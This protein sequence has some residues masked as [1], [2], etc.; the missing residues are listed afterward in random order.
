[1]DM[2]IVA[3]TSLEIQPAIAFLHSEQY[4]IGAKELSVLVAGVGGIATTYGLTS[5]LSKKKPGYIIQ[6]GIAG[7][8]RSELVPGSVACV[9]EEIMGDLGAEE[10][11]AFKDLFDL[12][13]ISEN[14]APF[15]KKSLKNPDA[16]IKGIA[17]LPSVR[18]V[19]INE[20]TTRKERIELIRLKYNPDIE[21]ME[22]AAFHYVC[23]QEN[24][25]FLQIRAISNYVGERDK[26]NWKLELAIANL[27]K[28]LI[29]VVTQF[30]S[31]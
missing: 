22:G 24:I 5:S 11:N 14:E 21:S 19:G 26:K 20:I 23:L 4:R 10:N 29:E 6:A 15:T 7:S 2:L 28:A 8:F 30:C 18:S 17:G 16:R 9:H 1:M 3:A 31:C 12:G 13:L 27:N 25:P